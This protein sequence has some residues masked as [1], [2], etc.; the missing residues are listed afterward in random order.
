MIIAFPATQAALVAS[1]G[2]PVARIDRR[3]AVTVRS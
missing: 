1:A 2:A 3:F